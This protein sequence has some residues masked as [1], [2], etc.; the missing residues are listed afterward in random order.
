MLN[1][2]KT[3]NPS[4]ILEKRIGA[5][6][7]PHAPQLSVII[8]AYNCAEFIVETLNSIFSQTFRDY[9]VILVNDGSPDTDKL[10]KTLAVYF[11]NIIYI[12]QENGGTAAARNTAI[13]NARGKFLAFL[14]S[15]DIW[16]PEYLKAQ[17]DAMAAKN[18]DMIYADALLFGN[19]IGKN[20]TFMKDCPSNGKVTTESLITGEC[21]VINSG[22]VAHRKKILAVGMFDEEL[23]RIGIEDF[24]L[25]FR[26][27]KSGARIEYQKKV[28]LKYRIHEQSL[29]GN[30][31]NRL[32]RD[33]TVLK[34]LET[35]YL[36]TASEQE[37]LKNRLSL[38][39]AT[40]Q[41]E[42]GK[43]NL[44]R[45]NFILAREN[46]REGN[47]YYKSIKYSALN[48]LL[49][50]SPKLILKLFI[51]SRPAEVASMFNTTSG[52]ENVSA[53]K[54]KTVDRR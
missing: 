30:L 31:L 34:L 40:L 18:C 8:P 25:W 47:Q 39:V 53:K 48:L 38:V 20:K 15:D 13:E 2:L 41:I 35:K 16:L 10:E 26:L 27:A 28:L 9:E 50:I 52:L 1:N 7:L 42:K 6:I 17:I 21:N 46:F 44:T 5:N 22:T 24:D 23:P 14:D 3:Q 45:G 4:K 37:K 29:S 54:E 19:L 32:E 51:K 33:V 12:K 49:A 36:L 11:D 43:Y